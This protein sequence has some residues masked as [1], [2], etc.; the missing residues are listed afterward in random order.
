M[1]IFSCVLSSPGVI[2]PIVN[3][4]LPYAA[5]TLNDDTDEEDG[6]DEDETGVSGAIFTRV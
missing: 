2:R 1:M 4:G 5:L 6:Y 3:I